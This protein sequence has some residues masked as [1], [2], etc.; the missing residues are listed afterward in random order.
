MSAMQPEGMWKPTLVSAVA[1]TVTATSRNSDPAGVFR[2][3]E[4][5]GCMADAAGPNSVSR[6]NADGHGGEAVTNTAQHGGEAKGPA[7]PRTTN[8]PELRHT[9]TQRAH[10]DGAARAA[11]ST[12]SE[13]TAGRSSDTEV[14]TGDKDDAAEPKS[15]DMRLESLAPRYVEKQHG[16]YLRRL[17]EAVKDPDNQNIAVTG[18]YGAGK[19]SV[20]DEFARKRGK[21]VLR[22]AI[23]TLAPGEEGESTTNRIQKE[24]VKQLLYGASAKVGRT[25]RFNKIAVLSWR[26]A[27]LQSALVVVPVGVLAYL[28]GVLPHMKWPG[29]DAAVF[30]RVLVWLG[31]AVLVTGLGSVVRML[32]YGRFNVSD[33]SAGGAALTLTAAPKTFFDKYIDEIVHYFAQEAKDFVVFED[34]DRFEDPYIFEALRELNVLLNSTPERRREPGATGSHQSEPLRFIY[35]VRDSVFSKIDTSPAKNRRE[36]ENS[37]ANGS[38]QDPDSAAQSEPPTTSGGARVPELDEAAAETKR[39]NRTKFFDIVIPLVPFISHRNARDLLAGLLEERGITGIERRLVNTVARHCTDMRL[40]RN[41]CNEY[42]VFRERLLEPVEPAKAAPDLDSTHL[43]ALVVYKNFH[44][45]DFE[46]ITRRDSDLD[47]LY[48]LAQRLVRESIAGLNRR[49]RDL[50]SKDK[51]VRTRDRDAE[52]MGKLLSEYADLRLQNNPYGWT[53]PRFSVGSTLYSPEDLA[54]YEFW[55]AVAE[56]RSLTIA[57]A[58]SETSNQHRNLATLD[59]NWL[60]TFVPDALQAHRWTEFDD[61]K[62]ARPLADIEAD[63]DLL[64]SATFEDLVKAPQFTLTPTDREAL[65]LLPRPEPEHP[66]TFAQLAAATL[67]SKLA[68]ELVRRGYID[69]N[70]SLYAA[71]FYGNFTGV[72]VATFMVQHVQPNVMSINYDLS[73]HRVG[74]NEGAAANLLAEAEDAGEELLES[75]AAWNIDIVNHLLTSDRAAA[76]VVAGQLIASWASEEPREFLSAYFTSERA[77]REKLASLLAACRWRHVYSY[78]VSDDG[79]PTSARASLV[80]AAVGG[81]DTHTTYELD[82]EVRDFIET[83]YRDMSLL[84][85]EEPLD[86]S[87][88]VPGRTEG[89]PFEPRLDRVD[90]LLQRTRVLF[91]Q[92]RPLRPDVRERA[93]FGGHYKLTAEN[94]RTALGLSDD[95]GVPLEAARGR[96]DV[97]KRCWQGLSSYLDAV[98][99]DE[100]TDYA[101]N[102]PETL[103]AVLEDL[104]ADFED[105]EVADTGSGAVAE[106][107][108]HTAP[109]ATL[110]QLQDAPESTWSAL[111]TATMFR[112]SLANFERYR[113]ARGGDVDEHLGGLLERAGRVHVDE[114]GDSIDTDGSELDRQDAAVAILNAG[115]LATQVRVDLATSLEPAAPLVVGNIGWEASDLFARLI[116]ADLV[117]DDEVT[118]ARL[119]LGGWA[120]LGPAIKLSGRIESFLSPE[121]LDGMVADALSDAGTAVKVAGEVLGNA[122][123]YVS[124]DDWAALKAVAKYADEH[125]V[126]LDP[127][128]VVRIARVGASHSDQDVARVLRLLDA[129]SPAAV[130]DHVVETFMHLGDPYNR[131]AIVRDSFELNFDD[132]HDRL[133]RILQSENRIS[134]GYP[135]IPKRRYSV[136]V[137]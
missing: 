95:E 72:D 101:V 102:T 120:A 3:V 99:N 46:N 51:R 104:V 121:L 21:K 109:A 40:M 15:A 130:A 35:A 127:A 91:A 79:V 33:V 75:V 12:A 1:A 48:D 26:Q 28:F 78:L 42:L 73:R 98:A 64:R 31:A 60:T 111:A 108:A 92:L 77:E 96:G 123:S 71:Q 2:W 67:K 16:T 6:A 114:D 131:I 112:A 22:L 69:R 19:S 23:S 137:N 4:D 17:E 118:F 47:R 61:A 5:T 70:F 38:A 97:Y 52:R 14:G 107:L 13:D 80:N 117:A 106:L 43:F 36:T 65:R 124:E 10:A 134:R 76:G 49:K 103:V 81:F 128:V 54:T 115:M 58:N 27:W 62:A 94:L 11:G 29:S 85:D 7:K 122:T 133:L 32:T 129:A 44:L 105:G 55:A 125:A 84:C 8:S 34:L 113:A 37:N 18:R 45:E 30:W 53:V 66:Q 87:D 116:A 50:E 25:S 39:A 63:I 93:V 136:T 100:R 132:V 90:T 83:H 9:V 119:R 126:A 135:R 82:D 89:Q 86:E 24:I 56:A 68:A 20:L 74:D 110:H 57:V 88:D 41:M 59:E